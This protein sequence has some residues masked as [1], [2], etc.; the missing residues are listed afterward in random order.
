M[1]QASHADLVNLFVR[2]I[3]CGLLVLCSVLIIR[4][5]LEWLKTSETFLT[6]QIAIE[7][8]ELL[9]ETRILKMSKLSLNTAIWH[10]D[11]VSAENEI[12]SLGYVDNVEIRRELPHRIHVQV[13]EKKPIALLRYKNKLYCLD[14]EGQVLPTEPGQ[15]YDMPIL[16]GNFTGDI[17]IGQT[18]GGAWVP[19]SLLILQRIRVDQPHLYSEISEMILGRKEGILIYTSRY[20]IPVYA[21]D[22]LS[23]PK[24]RVFDAILK[25]LIKEKK[26]Q[27]TRYIDLRFRG[28]VLVGGSV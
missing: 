27:Q 11:L 7:G 23:W 18:L 5:Y 24:I 6:D 17:Q 26:L 1:K 15:M 22:D 3:G 4:A 20:G 2:S 9:T 28:Q 25:E 10:F 12:E 21:G 13:M 14:R 8:N 19:K 16:S